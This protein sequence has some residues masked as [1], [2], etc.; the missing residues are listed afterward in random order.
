MMRSKKSTLIEFSLGFLLSA[1]IFAPLVAEASTPIE[2]RRLSCDGTST[3]PIASYNTAEERYGTYTYAD[4]TIQTADGIALRGSLYSN[5]KKDVI[6]YCH[7]LLSGGRSQDVLR[8]LVVLFDTHD[9]LTFDFRGHK[10]SF[11]SS[12]TGGD[13]ILDLR[14]AI[15]FA[16]SRGY[17]KVIVLGAGMGGTVGL[18]TAKIFRNIDALIVVS[19]SGFSPQLASFPVRFAS[20]V[21]LSTLFGKVPVRIITKTRL[22]SRYSAGFPIDIEPSIAPVPMLVIH[23]EKDRLVDLERF[24][25]VVE[26]I[27]E[28][29]NLVVIP[30]RKHA[31]DL[32]NRETLGI[33][34]AYL[35][36][37]FADGDSAAATS[38]PPRED[39]HA[40]AALDTDRIEI[41]GDLPVPADVFLD[42]LRQRLL[43][44]SK[45]LNETQ[46]SPKSIIRHLESVLSFR[47]YTRASLSVADPVPGVSVK[48]KIPRIH[49]LSITGNRFV[50]EEYIRKILRVDGDYYNAYELDSAIRRLSS[51]RTVRTVKPRIVER[52][53]GDLD[54]LLNVVEQ[55]SYRILLSTKFTDVDKFFGIGL[56]WNEFNPTGLQCETRAMLGLSEYDVLTSFRLSKSLLGG[57]FRFNSLYYDNIKSRDDLDYVFTRQEVREIGGEFNVRYRMSYNTAI[58]LGIFGKKY[59]APQADLDLPIEE[60]L[61]GGVNAKLDI[62]GKLPRQGPAR[63]NWKHTFYYQHMGPRGMGD[64]FFDLYQFNLTAKLKFLEHHSSKTTL[65]TGWVSGSA[66][67]QEQLSLGGMTT[68]PGYPDDSF[69]GTR[70]VM[71][72]QAFYLNAGQWVDETS[73]WAPVRLILTFH[74][75]TAW[76]NQEKF[77]L[78]NLRM[79]TGIEFDY[80][81]TL[82]V[83]VVL[84][85]GPLRRDSPR[86]YIGWKVHVL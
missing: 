2:E 12:T 86:V 48:I 11:G 54:I 45:G 9:L 5:N 37:L 82:R 16:R 70:M 84:S 31:D 61:A 52:Q 63:F 77:R 79:D 27:L 18:R 64:F 53:D 74:A 51:E 28:P 6:I 39:A 42:E 75:G 80:L 33:I 41:T 69:V 4:L 1:L 55:R 23:S 30:G 66:P 59:R 8:L 49:S 62:S 26:G 29:K 15:S 57:A 40:H 67:P 10:S 21:T 47:G 50:S 19:P 78:K 65:H 22:G 17:K 35:D 3:A 76:L 72:G 71:A 85:L 73:I 56:T 14:A 20:D 25:A 81:E 13:E 60:G 38:S 46:K 32:I 58:R 7:R 83:G 34:K 36:D 68:L 24:E 44:D 43:F